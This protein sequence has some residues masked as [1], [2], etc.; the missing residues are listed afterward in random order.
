MDSYLLGVSS[1]QCRSSGR[2]RELG[3]CSGY[4]STHDRVRQKNVCKLPGKMYFSHHVYAM[5]LE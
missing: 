5:F 2:L 4:S 3:P 1:V